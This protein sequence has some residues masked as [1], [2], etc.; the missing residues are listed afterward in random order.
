MTVNYKDGMT[1]K[2]EDGT[3]VPCWTYP[4]GWPEPHQCPIC[5]QWVQGSHFC[6]G[7]SPYPNYPWKTQYV[8][9]EPKKDHDFKKFLEELQ[10]M[11]EE[12]LN[13]S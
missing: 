10:K 2:Y 7:P 4:G 8:G 5:G 6:T 1:V 12:K 9:P 3:T 13:E 11:I